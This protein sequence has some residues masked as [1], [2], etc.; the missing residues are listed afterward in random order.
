MYC[1]NVGSICVLEPRTYISVY[2]QSAESVKWCDNTH[3]VCYLLLWRRA[4]IAWYV[5]LLPSNNR[6]GDTF[7]RFVSCIT[8]MI[9][10]E[11]DHTKRIRGEKLESSFLRASIFELKSWKKCRRRNFFQ[12]EITYTNGQLSRIIPIINVYR[13]IL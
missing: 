13:R 12:C 1:W 10:Y 9:A 5:K 3:L 11:H 8:V 6:A 2:I 4:V 7:T